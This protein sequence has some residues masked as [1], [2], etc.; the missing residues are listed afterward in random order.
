MR[1]E[2]KRL[3]FENNVA[4]RSG[5]SRLAT[6][7]RYSAV[8]ASVMGADDPTC[9]LLKEWFMTSRTRH[10]GPA[11]GGPHRAVP[12]FE[13]VRVERLVN[14]RLQ[15]KYLAE[16]QDI[17]GL[18]ERKVSP[19]PGMSEGA[20]VLDVE[21]FPGLALN[22]RGMR[23][24]IEARCDEINFVMVA[25]E[26]FGRRNQNASP[27]E[28]ADLLDR[29]AILAHDAGIPLSATISVAFGDPFEGEV[30]ADVVAELARAVRRRP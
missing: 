14:P 21:T 19:L 3:R 8:R 6:L 4:V 12:Q 13:V 26:G 25:S 9:K 28:T 29:I 24:A 2:N 23:R 30:S 16:V 5:L 18:C 22:E 7:S 10:R 27:E 11:A 20:T 15:E 1:S 17:A